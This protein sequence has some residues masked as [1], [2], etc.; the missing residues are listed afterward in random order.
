MLPNVKVILLASRTSQDDDMNAE[1]LT[2]AG[3]RLMGRVFG[4]PGWSQITESLWV[5][6]DAGRITLFSSL[7]WEVYPHLP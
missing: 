2:K 6:A 7:C 1:D 4:E 5:P 3:W